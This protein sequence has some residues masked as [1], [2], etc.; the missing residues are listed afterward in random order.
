VTVNVYAIGM[1]EAGSITP[2]VEITQQ[3]D[4]LSMI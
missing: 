3:G 4:V 2:N 1:Y